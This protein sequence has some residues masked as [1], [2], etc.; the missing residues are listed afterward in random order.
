MT[1][2][3]PSEQLSAGW[4][5]IEPI[6]QDGDEDQEFSF[7]SVEFGMSIRHTAKTMKRPLGISLEYGSEM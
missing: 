3:F 6:R 2:R 4:S 1:S 7:R 5:R